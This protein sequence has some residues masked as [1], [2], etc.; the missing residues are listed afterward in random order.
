VTK[1]QLYAYVRGYLDQ[2][3][4][5]LSDATLDT[6]TQAVEGHLNRSLRDHHRMRRR[7]AWP[8]KDD[9]IPLPTTLTQLK[10]VSVGDT[11]YQQYPTQQEQEASQSL[12][13]F[14]SY[15]NCIKVFPAPAEATTY[16]IDAILALPSLTDALSDPNW[17][18]E[19]H[20]D[21]YQR[22][23]L[24]EAAGFLRDPQSE[25]VWRQMFAGLV[26]ELRLQGWNEGITDGPKI[27][28]A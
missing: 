7:I 25:A 2:D 6:L 9:T 4:E 3:S 11:V 18:A 21:I 17:I 28:P 19:Y 13:S 24:A 16:L 26:E 1:T 27:R 20:A 10:Q 23:L 15:G 14:V 8:S 12:P 5:T 22:G